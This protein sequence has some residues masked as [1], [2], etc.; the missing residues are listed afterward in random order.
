MATCAMSRRD[1]LG[2]R[3]RNRTFGGRVRGELQSTKGGLRLSFTTHADQALSNLIG[4]NARRK[5]AIPD[6]LTGARR[7]QEIR[8]RSIA[9]AQ[10]HRAR[11][12]GGT[13]RRQTRVIHEKLA[14]IRRQTGSFAE[15]GGLCGREAQTAAAFCRLQLAFEL[16]L[17]SS[18]SYP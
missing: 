16:D 12:L 14:P 17:R 13:A 11:F 18:I 7:R 15:S 2:L 8:A 10:L 3:V 6:V 1:C 5:R 4:A 9:R